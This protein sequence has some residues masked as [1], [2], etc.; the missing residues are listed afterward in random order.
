MRKIEIKLATD[1]IEKYAS[2]MKTFG[3]DAPANGFTKSVGF[4]KK[5]LQDWI[6]K[7]GKDTSEIK[8]FFGIYSALSSNPSPL[9]T[10]EEEDRF[11]TI[12]WPYNAEGEP[13]KDEEGNDELPV[14]LGDLL[15]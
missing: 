8:I 1:C 5:E 12:L 4:N 7:L 3:V 2:Q 14:N 15:P 11:T 10:Q 9:R 6:Q 13:A